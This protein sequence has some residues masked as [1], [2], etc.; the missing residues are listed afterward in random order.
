MWNVDSLCCKWIRLAFALTFVSEVSLA[1]MVSMIPPKAP[2][3]QMASLSQATYMPQTAQLV[4]PSQLAPIK[5]VKSYR[6]WKQSK[7][8]EA[9]TRLK[10]LKEDVLRSRGLSLNAT[11]AGLSTSLQRMLDNEELQF[12]MAQDLTI[13]DYFIGYLARQKSL[14]QAIKEVSGKLSADEVAELMTA[15]ADNFFAS[16]PTPAV[17][18]PRADSG[19]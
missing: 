13:T 6:E 18:S 7:I 9:E 5:T 1:S 2:R 3:Q 15:Y 4:Q 10:N 8:S 16:K 17:Q 11:E 14:Q 19:L 12:A